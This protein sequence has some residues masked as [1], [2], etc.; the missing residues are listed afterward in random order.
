MPLPSTRIRPSG[1]LAR[2]TCAAPDVP[3]ASAMPAATV[4]TSADAPNATSSLIE[5]FISNLLVVDRC[6]RDA[7]VEM[8]GSRTRQSGQLAQVD[9]RRGRHADDQL[10][11]VGFA[12]NATE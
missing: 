6:A 2:S 1:E 8:R 10:A 3:P 7:R 5:R 9:I 11:R 4:A 12:V